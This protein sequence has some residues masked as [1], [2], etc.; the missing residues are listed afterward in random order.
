MSVFGITGN[1]ASGK[2]TVAKALKNK[3]AIVFSADALVH[4]YYR[5]KRSAVYKKVITSFPQALEGSCI[6]RKRLGKIVFSDDA[7]LSELE[8][9]VHPAVIAELKKWT[10]QMKKK[11][12]LAVAEVPLLFEKRLEGYFDGVILVYTKSDVLKKR[13]REKYRFSPSQIARRLSLYLPVKRKI[14]RADFVID[15]NEDLVALK[16]KANLLWKKLLTFKGQ[17]T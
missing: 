6:S 8:R 14:K 16:R 2:S 5:D 9:I 12:R 15:N 11:D 1:L 13:L 4:Q 7:R 10:R 3:G 17:S